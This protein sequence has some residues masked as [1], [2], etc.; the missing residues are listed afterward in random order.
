[1][2][3]E[4][5]YW[6]IVYCRESKCRKRNRTIRLYSD[7]PD[8]IPWQQQTD[9]LTANKQKVG[10]EVGTKE[11]HLNHLNISG[12]DNRDTTDAGFKIPTVFVPRGYP[13]VKKRVEYEDDEPPSLPKYGFDDQFEYYP[14][15]DNLSINNRTNSWNRRSMNNSSVHSVSTGRQ[16]VYD[17]SNSNVNDHVM[18]QSK[19]N[20]GNNAP[21]TTSS[22]KNDK[23]NGGDADE[24]KKRS[25]LKSFFTNKKNENKGSS[26]HVDKSSNN[27]TL[28]HEQYHHNGGVTTETD[29]INDGGVAV[30]PLKNDIIFMPV[31]Q[32][33][34]ILPHEERYNLQ[35]GRYN[36]QNQYVI[37]IEND[38][39]LK[40]KPTKK[41]KKAK[42]DKK[43]KKEKEDNN[44]YG[45]S[46]SMFKP[47]IQKTSAPEP[48]QLA[49]LPDYSSSFGDRS[50]TQLKVEN[51]PNYSL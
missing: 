1:M 37:D 22:I 30:I 19:I 39:E 40:Q 46:T 8:K 33:G 13:Y 25:K 11:D 42:K 36:Q 48:Q 38:E 44:M 7:V 29:E 18:F 9:T 6:K 14:T 28:P 27:N 43:E 23:Q 5:R 21:T 32:T 45:V 35:N 17:V 3:V 12:S 20:G 34:S 26:E 41:N 4:N 51:L 10:F 16:T 31:T 49:G 47:V 24:I 15:L 2:L 50:F